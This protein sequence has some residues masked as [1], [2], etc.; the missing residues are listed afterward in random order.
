MVEEEGRLGSTRLAVTHL[1]LDLDG[2]TPS[3]LVCLRRLHLGSPKPPCGMWHSDRT[4]FFNLFHIFSWVCV[5]VI[6][7]VC[8][9]RTYLPPRHCCAAFAPTVKCSAAWSSNIFPYLIPQVCLGWYR[10]SRHSW[11]LWAERLE[12]LA[13]PKRQQDAGD[14]QGTIALHMSE[15]HFLCGTD[16]IID[17]CPVGLQPPRAS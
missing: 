13:R 16:L 3:H 17:Y 14:S 11:S 7:C 5:C 9:R 2:R 4:C 15:N 10:S 8:A 1:E 12:T 6:V